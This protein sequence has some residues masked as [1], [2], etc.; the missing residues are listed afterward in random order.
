MVGWSAGD[1]HWGGDGAV[2]ENSG[3]E[4]IGEDGGVCL[5]ERLDRGDQIE[6]GANEGS[7][8][9]ALDN[10]EKVS[11]IERESS[12]R[13]LIWYRLGL[14]THL[15]RYVAGVAPESTAAREKRILQEEQRLAAMGYRRRVSVAVAERRKDFW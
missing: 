4:E 11:Y 6:H 14:P 7:G 9:N 1:A 2:E 10:I 15:K 3:E 8:S 13:Q 5:A 12:R